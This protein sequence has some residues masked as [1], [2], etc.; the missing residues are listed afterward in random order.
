MFK[1]YYF[2]LKNL[3]KFAARLDMWNGR[4]A[5]ERWKRLRILTDKLTW[6]ET[7]FGDYEYSSGETTDTASKTEGHL[8]IG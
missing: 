6:R 8:Q 5:A 1:F 3:F 2:I 7:D 4:P